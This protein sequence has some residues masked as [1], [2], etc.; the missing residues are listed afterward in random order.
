MTTE[1]I[2]ERK[3]HDFGLIFYFWF[4]LV[5]AAYGF[6]IFSIIK[7]ATNNQ[8]LIGWV[9]D[10]FSDVTASFGNYLW[11]AIGIA[12]ALFVIG[13]IFA[14]FQVWLMSYIGA[15]L[16]NT[17]VF[18]IPIVLTGAG[19]ASFFLFEQVWIGIVLIVPAIFLLVIAI[20]VGKR[21]VLG[22]KIFEMS[23]EAVNDEKE[24][25]LP[26]LFFAIL[27]IVTFVTGIAAAIY[28]GS[29]INYIMNEVVHSSNKWVEYLVFFLLIYVYL[30]IHWTMLHFSDAINI[31]IFKRWNNYKDSSIKYAM[32]DVWK[33]KGSIVL[34]GMFMAFFDA[35]IKT[36]QFFAARKFWKKWKQNKA[37]ATTLKVLKWVF[38]IFI[39]L[40]KWLFKILKFLNYYTLT[41]IVVEKQG[42][43]KSMVRSADLSLDS[44]ADVIIGKT[45]VSIAKGLFTIMTFGVFSVGG[46]FL[47]YYW[48]FDWFAA[49]LSIDTSG[50]YYGLGYNVWFSLAIAALFFFFGYLPTTAILRPISTA[51]K[52]ILF[53]YIADPFR[54][55][56]G[57]R[58]RLTESEDINES[59]EKVKT[60]VMETYDK[61]ERPTWNK[62]EEAKI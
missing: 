35:I 33:I 47:G 8:D 17:V 2:E 4:L 12:G 16:V 39:L 3:I 9:T 30:A 61:E 7:L 31:C 53:F 43:V 40:L 51:Y 20:L 29:N 42:F 19:I 57:R 55:H 28:T 52:T 22:S 60:Q 26:V 34:F 36:I 59:L 25:L 32:K 27:S 58:T 11:W 41:I 23:N 15:E 46:F 38:I 44:A 62:P 10:R 37:W 45:G 13:V 48:L 54:G 5:I 18:G 24:T 50:S 49:K 1:T 14:Y 21:V 6:G 56:P